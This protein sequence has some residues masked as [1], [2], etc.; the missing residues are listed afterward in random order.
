[1]EEIV[2]DVYTLVRLQNVKGT[3]LYAVFFKTVNAGK[4][5]FS[6]AKNV[7]A[8]TL[9]KWYISVTTYTECWRIIYIL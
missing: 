3:G 6:S 9:H 1:M 2:E 8:N 5:F 7:K 4:S